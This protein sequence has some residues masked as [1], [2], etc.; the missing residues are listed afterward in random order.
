MRIPNRSSLVH[1]TLEIL[2][3]AILEREWKDQ[4]PSERVLC[5]NY[6]I[7][8]VTLRAALQQLVQLGMISSGSGRPRR[9][10]QR[11]TTPDLNPSRKIGLL[12]LTPRHLLPY[13]ASFYVGE[14]QQILFPERYSLHVISDKRLARKSPQ[15]Y[16]VDRVHQEGMAAWILLS[17][18]ESVQRWFQH[19]KIPALVIGLCHEGVSLTSIDLDRQATCRHA[20]GLLRAR[21]HDHIAFL[22]S[23]QLSAGMKASER[24]FIEGA[25]P[26]T[27]ALCT[28]KILTH[29]GTPI[30]IGRCLDHCLRSRHPPTGIVSCDAHHTLSAASYLISRQYKLPDHLSLISRDNDESLQFFQPEITRYT[31]KEK[32]LA[33]KLGRL[34]LQLAHQGSIPVLDHRITPTL[35]LG[36][37]LGTGK[38]P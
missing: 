7:S 21:G 4:L 32:T 14:L 28:A 10:L 27:P 8:R 26:T 18:P 3:N 19:N 12:S 31:F 34:A 6:Q 23:A 17:V 2:R 24:G 22:K 1:K 30:G 15:S 16:L 37:T 9:I 5:E 13:P 38:R 29:D 36:K 35:I 33:Q 11:G 25:G 20:A